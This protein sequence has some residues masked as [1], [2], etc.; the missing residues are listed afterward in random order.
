MEDM[1]VDWCELGSR[2]VWKWSRTVDAHLLHA[3]RAQRDRVGV[4]GPGRV[5]EGGLACVEAQV[6][7]ELL[8]SVDHVH[9]DDCNGE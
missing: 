5:V 9:F 6:G 1:Y 3:L 4:V 7:V 8:A 2:Y